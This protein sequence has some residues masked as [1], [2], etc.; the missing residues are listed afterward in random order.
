MDKLMSIIVAN[1][2][3]IPPAQANAGLAANPSVIPTL[4]AAMGR[5][6]GRFLLRLEHDHEFIDLDEWPSLE[7]YGRFLSE[8][9]A[10]LDA[11]EAAVGSKAIEE[12]WTVWRPDEP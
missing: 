5:L 11:F 3:P 12:I 10:S 1:K 6:G 7:V 2:F 8:E 9:R 4:G